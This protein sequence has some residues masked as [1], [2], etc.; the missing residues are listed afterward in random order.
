MKKIKKLYILLYLV[1]IMLILA[2]NLGSNQF[3]VKADMINLS[4]TTS[5]NF[6]ISKGSV[7]I[8]DS[9]YSG[10]DGSGTLVSGIP[11]DNLSYVIS[12]SS[13]SATTNTI[14]VNVTTGNV[15]VVL[16]GVNI[17]TSSGCAMSVTN[18]APS[19]VS[20]ILKIILKTFYIVLEI[21]LVLKS[22][23]EKQ[24]MGYYFLRVKKDIV[25][26]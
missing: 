8:T 3:Y 26:I 1:I 6:D 25:N 22:L 11:S 9:E 12:Q 17:Q 15:I 24:V 19:T 21:E 14:T 7:S 18:T 20:V 5:I 4:S 10:Y 13:S 16:N 2:L 23:A